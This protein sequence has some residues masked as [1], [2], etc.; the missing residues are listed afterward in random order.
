[1]EAPLNRYGHRLSCPCAA[2][3]GVSL[4]D[5]IRSGLLPPSPDLA[6]RLEGPEKAPEKP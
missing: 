1:M 5:L 4:N 3:A 2:C 6:R